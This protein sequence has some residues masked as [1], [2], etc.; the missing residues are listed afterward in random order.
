MVAVWHDRTLSAGQRADALLA[1]MSLDEKIGQL[2]SYWP[3]QEPE[4][5]ADGSSVGGEVAPME[6]AFAGRPGFATTAQHG[7]GQLTRVFGSAPIEP[8]DGVARL[9]EFQQAVMELNRFRIPAVAHEECL[10]GFTAYRATVYPAAIAWGATFDPAL[11]DEMA[12]RIGSDMRSLGIH[13]GLSPLLDVVRDYRWGR[14]EETL[15]EDP[16]VVGTLGTAYVKGLQRAGIVATLKHFVGYPAGRAGR[17]HAP[18]PMGKRE[19]EDVMLPPFEMA[20]R[21]GGVDSVMNSYSDIDGVPPAASVE[22]LTTVLRERWG[23]T[24]T[25]VSD[26]WAVAFLHLMH[27]VADSLAEAGAQ[28][29]TAGLDVELPETGGFYHLADQV[30]SGRLDEALVDRAA[31]RV[32]TQKARL[33]LLDEGWDPAAQGAAVDLDPPENRDLARR[34]A[35]ASVVLLANPDTTSSGRGALPLSASVRRVAVVGPCADDPLTFMG[36]YAFPNHVLARYGGLGTGVEVPT[37]VAALRAEWPD[38]EVVLEAGVPVLEA[39]RSGIPAAVAAAEGAEVVVVAVGDRAGMFGTGTSGEGC[40]SVDLTL[41]GAQSDLVEALLATGTPVV[42]VVVSGRPY[43]LGA[44]ASRCAAVVQAF[45]PGEAGG[46]AVAGVISGRLNPS[47]KLPVGVPDHPGGQP[48]TYLVA[49]LSWF[50]E[51][52]SN[53][54]P[55]PLYP[56]GHGLSYTSFDLSD[57]RLGATEVPVDGSVTVSVTVAN[58]GDRAGSEVVQLY[59][60]DEY[61]SVVR[62]VKQL[63]GYVKVPLAAGERRTVSFELHTDRLSFTGVD[64]RRIVEPGA[65]DVSVGTSSEDRPLRARITLVGDTRVVGEGR[66]L[67]TPVTVA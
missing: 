53:L 2:G 34:V 55:R 65:I 9:A 27:K 18:V 63:V 31:R 47:G 49:P 62:P 46:S 52:I 54:D 36:C 38:A 32:L 6:S 1:E 19:L 30:R 16:Y 37:L 23:F 40:D 33:G 44:F 48:G 26:Y 61:A 21:E 43:S 57:L 24:G 12:H 22:L 3:R 41:P 17:N 25:V 56:F 64:L 11:V 39:D 29:L 45:M 20:V 42:L 67:L 5:G 14:V 50:S 15:G 60:S 51:G 8:A 66:V 7:L 13:Q 4:T 58:T 10:T 35:E 59:V 28:A